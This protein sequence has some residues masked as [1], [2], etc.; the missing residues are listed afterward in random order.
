MRKETQGK[1]DLYIGS[2]LKSQ[3]RDKVFHLK[4]KEKKNLFNSE[5]EFVIFFFICLKNGKLYL[6]SPHFARLMTYELRL[7]GNL[8]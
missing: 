8:F 7:G 1:T 6:Q 3:P 5:I 4:G 2:W